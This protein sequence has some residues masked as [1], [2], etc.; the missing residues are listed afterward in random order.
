MK[1]ISFFLMTL[2][3]ASFVSAVDFDPGRNITGRNLYSI[4]DFRIIN[5]TTYFGDGSQLTGVASGGSFNQS[6]QDKAD[7]NFTSNNFNGTGNFTTTGSVNGT[8]VNGANQ[9]QFNALIADALNWITNTVNDLTNYYTKTEVD[10]NIEG[11]LSVARTD[12]ESNFT[13]LDEGKFNISEYQSAFNS[14]VSGANL[15]DSATGNL[16]YRN[17]SGLINEANISDLAHVS[18]GNLSWN[19]TTYELTFQGN[20]NSNIT[21]LEFLSSTQLNNTYANLSRTINEANIS[22]L[23]HI[24]NETVRFQNLTTYSCQG[25]S[26]MIGAELNGTPTCGSVAGGGDFSF[27]DYQ[28]SFDKN[29][30]GAELISSTEGNNTYRNLSSTFSKGNFTNAGTLL[31]DWADSEIADAISI[32]GGILGANSVSGLWT[33]TGTWTLGDDGDRIDIASDTWDVANGVMSG[34]VTLDT[35]QGANELYDMDQNVLEASNV[36]FVD[37]TSSGNITITTNGENLTIGDSETV[38]NGTC[39]NTYVQGTLVQ[40]IGCA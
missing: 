33:T 13:A 34:V 8:L 23:T 5:A 11:N 27:G 38:Y 4:D 26:K 25:T 1:L 40:S 21:V 36:I 6:Y 22:D 24:G 32:I 18:P 28:A 29:V 20:F 9:I 2:F 31:F 14:N 10:T 15:L 3:L 12:I 35:G 30:T 7:Y 17:L 16:T 19:Q 37:I 39:L